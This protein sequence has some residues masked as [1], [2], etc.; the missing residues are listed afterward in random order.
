MK[1]FHAIG[2]NLLALLLVAG[3]LL[4][5][6]HLQALEIGVVA[7]LAGS[8]VCAILG[9][10][11]ASASVVSVA[12]AGHGLAC[13]LVAGY[14]LGAEQRAADSLEFIKALLAAIPVVALLAT[15]IVVLLEARASM[16]SS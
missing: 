15:V 7:M 11:R 16:R 2:L 8:A 9:C 6:H 3:V 5:K 13:A 1:Y 4:S 10:L 12:V 14:L